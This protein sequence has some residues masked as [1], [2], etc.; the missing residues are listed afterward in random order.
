LTYE[1][2]LPLQSFEVL[3]HLEDQILSFIDVFVLVAFDF[4]RFYYFMFF[5]LN[6]NL[7]DKIQEDAFILFNA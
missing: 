1:G 4:E 6:Q 2:W 5:L 7:Y 3:N